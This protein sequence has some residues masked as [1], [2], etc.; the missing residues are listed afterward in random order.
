MSIICKIVFSFNRFHTVSGVSKQN[1][2][3]FNIFIG[4]QIRSGNVWKIFQLSRK[5]W[6]KKIII[7]WKIIIDSLEEMKIV[8]I[9]TAR[10]KINTLGDDTAI[11]L[12]TTQVLR[13]V[14][15][16][17]FDNSW[18]L[19][20]T[21]CSLLWHEKKCSKFILLAGWYSPGRILFIK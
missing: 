2:E 8:L 13:Y 9:E 4:A 3:Y 17:S 21:R 6:L 11:F 12:D 16:D 20:C 7:V 15:T 19:F 5:W 10:L 18:S 14:V 1:C